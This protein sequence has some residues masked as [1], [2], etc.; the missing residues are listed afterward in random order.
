MEKNEVIYFVWC[1]VGGLISG[2]FFLLRD[3][4]RCV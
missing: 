2:W 1:L 3:L 4:K